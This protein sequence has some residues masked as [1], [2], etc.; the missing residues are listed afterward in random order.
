MLA[1]LPIG[2]RLALTAVSLV[3]VVA[4]AVTFGLGGGS[5]TTLLD[6]GR[7]FTSDELRQMPAAFRAAK[8]TGFR[9]EGQ[10]VMALAG[11]RDPRQRTTPQ[12]RGDVQ[13]RAQ[14]TPRPTNPFPIRV[15]R[16]RGLRILVICL[17]PP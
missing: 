13:L 1:G 10:R 12:V 8:L 5:N 3:A 7:S 11:G 2:Q 4:L 16:P 6:D 17:S 9:V 14:P 15:F